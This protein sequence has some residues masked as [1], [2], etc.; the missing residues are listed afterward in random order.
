MDIRPWT[1]GSS[2]TTSTGT[3]RGIPLGLAGE[4]IPF[5]SRL[6]LVADAYDAITTD[7]SY[8][9]ATSP[10]QALE[11]LLET[12]AR[13]STR[14][15]SPR[16][17]LTSRGWGWSPR[18]SSPRSCPSTSRRLTW[19]LALLSSSPSGSGLR[20]GESW[21]LAEIRLRA[22][23]SSSRDHAPGDRPVSGLPWRTHET[24]ASVLWVASYGLLV[25]AALLNRRITGVP[26][27]ATGMLNL[28]AILANG[29][30]MPVGYEAMH[31]AGRVSE[32]RELDG[33]V[34]AEP[35][36]ARRPLGRPDWLPL[37]NVFSVGD[38]VIAVG[39]FVIVLAGMGV[40]VRRD[41]RRSTG[42]RVQLCA[43]CVSRSLTRRAP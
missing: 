36:L 14:L 27:V 30:T 35:A 7:R 10:E 38:V 29:G 4:E 2:T 15:S 32:T 12:R 3:A 23:G 33:D 20:S 24:V 9:D 8:R 13:S 1:S 11:E 42:S 25:V 37:A 5:G 40:R 43:S 19:S 34:G 28:A 26:V 6:I 21:P 17:R 31:A 22:R 41:M 39:A 18:R 16:S